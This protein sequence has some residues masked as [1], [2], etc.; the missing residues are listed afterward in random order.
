MLYRE[1]I[2]VI[3]STQNTYIHCGQNVGLLCVKLVAYI[4]TTGTES[5]VITAV[6]TLPDSRCGRTGSGVLELCFD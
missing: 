2:A 4:V 5:A 1:I 3:R 6:Q